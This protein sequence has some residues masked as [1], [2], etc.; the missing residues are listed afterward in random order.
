MSQQACAP[1]DSKYLV[2]SSGYTDVLP[3]TALRHAKKSACRASSPKV[4]EIVSGCVFMKASHHG[5]SIFKGESRLELLQNFWD[6]NIKTSWKWRVLCEA[7]SHPNRQDLQYDSGR[8]SST[9]YIT[10]YTQTQKKQYEVEQ[11]T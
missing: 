6:I 4:W 2:E 8:L 5:I 1:I 10:G 7:K 11:R 9:E 3:M